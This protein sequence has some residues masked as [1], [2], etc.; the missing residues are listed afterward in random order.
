MSLGL[1]ASTTQGIM[2]KGSWML[3]STLSQSED[4][5][6]WLSDEKKSASARE[7]TSATH[8][9]PKGVGRGTAVRQSFRPPKTDESA[10]CA[11]GA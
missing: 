4:W 11:V 9:K 1:A 3:C 5:L 7:G 2:A 6:S 10:G 8:L